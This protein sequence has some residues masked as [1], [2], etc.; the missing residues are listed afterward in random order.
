MN[1]KVSVIV[2]VW[3][4]E[5]YIEKCA[6][7]LFEQTLDDIEFIFVD[8][9]TPDNSIAI[10]KD[11]L[12]DYPKR[13][14]L[15]RIVQY[16]KN[17]GLPQA[18]KAG[19]EA[20]TGNFIT[21]CDSD[22]WLAPNMYEVLLKEAEEKQL[23]LVF[24]DFVYISDDKTLWAPKYDE[25]KTSYQLKQGL[26]SVEISNA[27]WTKMVRRSVYDNEIKFPVIAMD[28]DDV[29]TSQ[30]A[31]YSKSIGYVNR[32]LYYHYAN[33]SSMTH[34]VSE[35]KKR[36][37]LQ[38]KVTNRKWIIDFF[39]KQNDASLEYPLFKYKWMVKQLS[40]EADGKSARGL[41]PEI[42]KIMVFG[43]GLS[44]KRRIMNFTILYLPRLWKILKSI[45]S[46]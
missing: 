35:E 27:V 16:E 33:P 25:R 13:A 6:R 31:Y 4:V 44:M 12:R 20:C 21:Y 39:E 28:E 45:T 46:E 14:P 30:L 2:P 17:R 41:Y 24:C 19:F 9:C 15:T 26:L 1:P 8:D 37:N 40:V 38:D 5:K 34:V 23:D 18:R 29:L 43:Q 7:S 36:K 42:N 32:C 22:D 3:G 10:I 11:V